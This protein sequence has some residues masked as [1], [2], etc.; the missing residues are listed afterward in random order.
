MSRWAWGALVVVIA[1]GAVT[2]WHSYRLQTHHLSG[3][4]TPDMDPV[5]LGISAVPT[6]LLL[7]AGLV[8][9]RSRGMQLSV[10]VVAA[11]VAALRIAVIR[12]ELS[13]EWTHG[14]G[15]FSAAAWVVGM[16]AAVVVAIVAAVAVVRESAH[17]R[18]VRHAE[19]GTADPP[20]PQ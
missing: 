19:P 14:T 11:L 4:S 5:G 3:L 2:A 8:R 10:A 13:A 17:G 9:R 18:R 15:M 16:G 7:A 20:P 6:G 12:M 1:T